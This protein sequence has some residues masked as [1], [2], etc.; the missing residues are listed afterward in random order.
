MPSTIENE[1]FSKAQLSYSDIHG[2]F[3]EGLV[4]L[5]QKLIGNLEV[6]F[7]DLHK[8]GQA[9]PADKDLIT[10][11]ND[12][13]SEAKDSKSFAIAFSAAGKVI[14]AH[15]DYAREPQAFEVLKARIVQTYEAQSS[16]PGQSR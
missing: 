5:L 8:T 2:P 12:L 1:I 4:Y 14:R 11:A 9:A 16:L 3:S 15:T 7:N 13:C 6:T 10:L